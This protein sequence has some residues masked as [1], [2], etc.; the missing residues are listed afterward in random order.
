M[1][2]NKGFTIIELLAVLV[3]LITILLIGIPSIT[4]TVERNKQNALNKKYDIIEAAGETYVNLYF[5]NNSK[6][7]TFISGNCSIDL[8]KIKERGLLTED[9]LKDPD[10]KPI[11]GSIKYDVTKKEYVY[12]GSAGTC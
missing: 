2:N 5:K 8:N 3:I 12:I 7:N 11:T 6:Y 1:K 4:S 10:N 9:D